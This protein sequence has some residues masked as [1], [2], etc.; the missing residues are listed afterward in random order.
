VCVWQEERWSGRGGL[1]ECKDRKTVK[2]THFDPA[3]A[4]RSFPFVAL[5][6]P[7]PSIPTPPR[8]LLLP[9]ALLSEA[10]FVDV[11]AAGTDLVLPIADVPA[12]F[13]PF[14]ATPLGRSFDS[15]ATLLSSHSVSSPPASLPG[16]KSC[17]RVECG[18]ARRAVLLDCWDD[19]LRRGVGS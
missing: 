10:P 12:L 6:F 17:E 16:S 9:A 5:P 13:F 1:N 19:R 14:E 15:S 7:A 2:F 8:L 11:L 3:G 18:T 4:S